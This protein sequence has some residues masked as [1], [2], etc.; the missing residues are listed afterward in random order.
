[1]GLLED[2][3]RYYDNL[4]PRSGKNYFIDGPYYGKDVI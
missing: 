2:L 3:H 4:P 1:M